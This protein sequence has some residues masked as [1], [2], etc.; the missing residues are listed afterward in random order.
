[1]VA[2]PGYCESQKRDPVRKLRR[3]T[4]GVFAWARHPM[5][6]V[7]LWAFVGTLLATLNWLV[8]WIVTGLVFVTLRR[9]E[10]EE[11]ILIS[12]FGA[13]YL[14]YMRTVS[15]LGPPWGCLGFDRGAHAS[16]RL[17]R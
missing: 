17:L 7:F 10:T 6:A 3:T 1:M 16:G 5:Y 9:I 4:H 12:L 15:A 8:A 2:V 14:E 13:E 11:R